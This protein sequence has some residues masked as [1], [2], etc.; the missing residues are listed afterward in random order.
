MFS[1]MKSPRRHP[2]VRLPV[3]PNRIQ[4]Q[5][6]APPMTWGPSPTGYYPDHN[7]ERQGEADTQNLVVEPHW[8]SGPNPDGS[9]GGRAVPTTAVDAEKIDQHAFLQVSGTWQPAKNYQ[10]P[11]GRYDPQTDGPGQPELRL[12]MHYYYRERGASRTSYMDVPDGRRFSNTGSQDGSSTTWYQDAAAAMAPYNIDPAAYDAKH[13][14]RSTAMPDSLHQIPAGPSH[15][16]S[17]IPV[18]PGTAL[19]R[20]QTK[21]RRGQK[22]VG[23]NRLANSTYAGQTYSQSTRHVS[24]PPG[25]ANTRA[26]TGGPSVGNPWG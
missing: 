4:D 26:G 5:R 19:I 25:M 21:V 3:Q 9:G 14:E 8:A 13:P 12:L 22:A 18:A 1:F 11:T 2:S 20:N 10:R 23:Q 6:G 24:N 7:G 16:W 17:E 15:G